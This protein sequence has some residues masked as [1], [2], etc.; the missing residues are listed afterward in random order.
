MTQPTEKPQPLFDFSVPQRQSLAAI[1]ILFVKTWFDVVKQFW[2][3]FIILLIRGNDDEAKGNK[4]LVQGLVMVGLG[5]VVGIVVALL[6][7]FYYR[8]SI[9]GENLVILT[10]A[11]KKKTL[12]IPLKNIQAVH[13]EQN[14]WQQ[15]FNVVKVSFDSTGSDK[16]EAEI[17]ALTI[18]K[19]TALKEAI[20]AVEKVSAPLELTSDAEKPVVLK[21]SKSYRMSASDILKLSLSANHLKAFIILVFFVLSMINDLEDVFR[22]DSW[23]LVERYGGEVQSQVQQQIFITVI[24]LVTVAAV[25]SVLVSVLLTLNKY[26]GFQLLDEGKQWRVS[27]GLLN[28]QQKLIP[29]N[30]VQVFSW[31]ANWLRRKINYWLT[32]VKLVGSDQMSGVQ[33]INHLPFVGQSKIVELSKGYYNG[34]IANFKEA[35]Q[36]STHY[37]RRQLIIFSTITLV[38]VAASFYWLRWH[39]AWLLLFPLYQYGRVSVWHRNFRWFANEDTLQVQS[40]V[41]GRKITLMRFVKVQQ[42]HLSQNVYQRRNKLA[43][44]LF[45]TAGGPVSLPYLPV[46]V[47]HQIRNFVLYRIET[48]SE[49]W[50]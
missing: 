9:Q 44:L 15:L 11:F 33:K 17:D 47:A 26:Y 23:E 41:W 28:K 14:L 38:L 20:M 45:V 32:D 48:T 29:V 4:R 49:H 34:A 27:H 19:A 36:V 24:F 5:T 18:V 50:M 16:M 25:V 31:E 2:P 7:Y 13:L 1:L 42:V 3:L 46:A 39:S 12:T 10:G 37:K 22:F 8:F 30:K 6:K 35:H 43:T 40:G 21:Q